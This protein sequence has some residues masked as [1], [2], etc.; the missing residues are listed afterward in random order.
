MR[1]KTELETATVE[2]ESR[3]RRN[4]N[5]RHIK[6]KN[7][8]YKYFLQNRSLSNQEKYKQ[9]RNKVNNLLHKAKKKYFCSKLLET[10][11]DIRG[12]WSIINNLL[13]KSKRISPQYILSDDKKI[14]DS[15][16]I[17][18]EFNSYFINCCTDILSNSQDVPM[19]NTYREYLNDPVS[20]SLFLKPISK[21]EIIEITKLL[22]KSSSCGFDTIN[23]NIVKKII[24]IIVDPLCY[25]FNLSI[26]TGIVPDKLKIAKIVP[27]YKKNDSH[28]CKNYRPISILP[29]FSKI[30]EKC[31]YKRLYSFLL[32]NDILT[33]SQYGFR[34]NHS[35]C[36]AL[37]DLQDK[38]VSAI[39]NNKFGIGTFIDLSKAFDIVNHDILLYK[40]QH[41]GVH[42]L[43]LAWFK[44]YLGNRY[45]F[46]V[47]NNVSSS[48]SLIKHGVPQGSILGPLLFLIYVND[49]EKSSSKFDFIMYA[50][51]TTLFYTQPDLKNLQENV[52]SELQNVSK[53][54]NANKLVLNL[55]KTS[56]IYFHNRQSNSASIRDDLTLSIDDKPLIKS[57][58]VSFLG[59][60]IDENLNWDS[61]INYIGTKISKC[62]GIMYKLRYCLPCSALFSLYNSLILSHIIY[63]IVV[64]G[65][66]AQTKLD[67]IFKLQ[68]KAIRI[69]TNSHYLAKSS[70]LFHKMNTLNLSHLYKYHSALL[71]FSYLKNM[72]PRNILQM[73][74]INSKIHSHSTRNSHLFH[75]WKV[76]KLYIQRS[77]RFSFPN[78][79]N[80]LP[81]QIHTCF[82]LNPFKRKLKQ[83]FLSEY[84]K[85]PTREP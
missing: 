52:N 56:F 19:N 4:Q 68:K 6:K 14:D 40:L 18:N 84:T 35:T 61:H 23:V 24:Y 7:K 16:S 66:C 32:S 75:L 64:W 54:F 44:N 77:V 22:R 34:S 78:V 9:M 38:I 36:H 63:C 12:T 26:T 80:S 25:I 55:T 3:W 57:K 39:N 21:C 67:K 43:P 11:N 85:L 81:D 74:N 69:C 76:E 20:A 73:F 1:W 33:N 41:Y 71:G 10:K 2:E 31:I 15:Q 60:N 37:I 58:S 13:C 62:I 29:C 48:H 82:F 65:N 79:W 30:L 8:Y 49:I 5:N 28:L 42:G 50:D 46:T 17:A 70:P 47:F 72:L 45:Q 59:V 51:D 53:W 83:Y 27:I